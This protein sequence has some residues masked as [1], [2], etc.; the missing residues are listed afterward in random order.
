M[1][2][3]LRYSWRVAAGLLLLLALLY[4][5]AYLYVRANKA[6]IIANLTAQ[7]GEKINGD[8]K[9][10][11]ADVSFF[12]S[13][14]RI[15]IRAQDVLIT[16]SLYARHQQAFFKA[17]DMFVSVNIFRMLRKQSPVRGIR[18]REA[19]IFIFTDSNGYSNNYLLRSKKEPSG[20]PKVTDK[21]ITLSFID[22]HNVS[23]IKLDAQR[24]KNFNFLVYDAAI[25]LDDQGE[26][27]QIKA[28]LHLKVN[29]LAFNTRKGSFLQNTDFKSDLKLMYGKLDQVLTFDQIVIRLGGHSFSLNG[30]FD[31]GEKNPEFMLKVN[32]E[33]AKY[34]ALKQLLPARIDSSLSQVTL[35]QPI[36]ATA[37]LHGPLKGGEPYITVQFRTKG[38]NMTTPF[39]DFTEASFTGFYKNEVTPG[40]P[41]KDPNS[42]IKLNDFKANWHGLP[43][44]SGTI[45]VLN[46]TQ[47]QLHCDLRSAFTLPQLNELM[48][49]K[50]LKL[51]A[52]DATVLLAYDGPMERNDNTNSFL[53]GNI[54]IS[55][56]KAKYTPRNVEL[57][58]L[59]GD[60]VFRNSNVA[61][62]KMRFEVLGNKIIMNGNAANALTLIGSAPN[63]VILDYDVYSPDLNL[64]SFVFL[65]GARNN[66][67]SE[68][69]ATLNSFSGRLDRLLDQSRINLALHTDKMRYKKFQAN[70]VSAAVTI[71]QNE[72]LLDKVQM[73]TAGGG[74]LVSGKLLQASN[75]MHQASLKA[76]VNHVNV[77]ELFVAFENFGQDGIS[78]QNLQGSLDAMADVR[79]TVDETGAVQPLSPE[80]T[81][82]FSLKK[83]K[84]VNF[85]PIK[86]IQKFVFK[87]RDFDNIE[88]AELKNAMTIHQGE[89]A[90]PRM[91][92]Q[93]SVL[94]LFVEGLYS[95]RGNT[96]MSVQIPLS[97]LK[98]RDD[99]YIPE[100]IG[101]DKKGGRSIFLRGQPGSDGNVQFKL[102][103]FKRYFKDKKD[104]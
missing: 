30:K 60:I 53:N 4:F 85:E 70:A 55:N 96:D 22:L 33:D 75:K 94:S 104:E 87:N 42:V 65:L 54:S 59:N 58:G 62:N 95:K 10:G 14:P 29:S 84:L 35:T 18:L 38:T 64:A 19:R 12:A 13:F 23:L 50:S 71:L 26:Q 93:S 37:D 47:P 31:L 51:T 9:I 101:T 25:K 11:K 66:T 6:E 77:Q 1:K 48:N 103:L 74:M 89:I 57:T 90:I 69:D 81:I 20:G 43:I 45:Q 68:T 82:N 34:A 40:L 86:K 100:N 17:K 39:M 52:G 63:K 78:S 79:L 8:V 16:D 21:E 98:K 61:L 99:D 73:N 5:L 24:H 2:T 80:G 76:N 46:L 15:S 83:G 88:F 56:G 97:N 3:V 41:R 28:D 27:L 44:K 49:A 92:I 91:E 36:S 102:D 7:L 72:Y 32:V 67:G